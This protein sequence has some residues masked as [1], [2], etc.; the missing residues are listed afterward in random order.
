MD[1]KQA[2][3]SA[4]HLD[5]VDD[6]SAALLLNTPKN[7]RVMLWVMVLFVLF[8]IVWASFAKLDKVT[9]GTGKVIPSSQLQVVQN[10]EG[11][12]VKDMLIREGQHVLKGQKLLLIDDTLFRSDFREKSQD[13]ASLQAESL[14]LNS[15]LASVAVDRSKEDA[16]DT[17]MLTP[18]TLQFSDDF[19]QQHPKLVART[20][21]AYRD[22]LANLEN[23]L[24]VFSQQLHQKQ[25]ELDET[26]S[27]VRNLKESYHIAAKELDITKPL[28]EEG[29]VPQIELLKLQRSLNDIQRDLNSAE[30]QIPVIASS[31]QEAIFKYV[32]IALKFRSDTQK[33]LNDVSN[34]LAALTETSVGLKDRVNRTT[35]TSPVTG[36]IQKLYVNTVGG[37]IQ[38]GMPLIEIV[39]T[40]DTLLIEAKIAPQDIG[41]LRPE[42]KAIVKFSAYDFTSYGGLDGTV[43]TISADTIQDEEGNSFYQVRIRTETS[44]LK[45]MNDE[46]LPIIPGMTASVDII[47]GKRTVLDYLLKPILKASHTALRE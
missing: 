24:A 12:I 14:R 5:Y 45:G 23:Q 11:G 7:A 40:E 47:T 28:A 1:T 6:K 10:L 3:V 18:Q 21:G 15:L 39:P 35:V 43:E 4:G 44:S 34:R 36:T 16:G 9:S 13:L 27:R 17:V 31:I 46:P 37:V 30:L 29:V 2:P 19:R 32:D 8:A 25:R 38:P 33:E 26:R 41:F 42:L 22:N 20:A